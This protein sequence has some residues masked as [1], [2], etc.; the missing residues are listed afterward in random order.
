[1]AIRESKAVGHLKLAVD[2]GYRITPEGDI[3]GPSGKIKGGIHSK[4][5]RSKTTGEMQEYPYLHFSV[6][7]APGSNGTKRV[8][9]HQ[10]QGYQLFGDACLEKGIEVRHRNGNSLDNSA[11]NID[12]G[13]SRSN[14]MDRTPEVRQRM[15]QVAANARKAWSDDDVRRLRAQRAQ[16]GKV[17]R[18]AREEGVSK[19]QMSEM[20]SR[21]TYR[22]VE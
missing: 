2:K 21:A 16:G 20:L 17:L 10:L 22:S 9:A 1:M 13:T 19:G 5:R 18:M 12:Y 15:A 3:I 8:A 11:A 14:S 6:R 7:V 4:K